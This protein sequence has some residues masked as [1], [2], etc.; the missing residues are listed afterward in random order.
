MAP[1]LVA[2]MVVAFALAIAGTGHAARRPVAVIDL[3]GAA[4][5]GALATDLY[6]ALVDHAELKPLDN[7]AFN[8][9]LQGPF[10]D[11]DAP[12]LER[13]QRYRQ[14]A[15][16][17]LAQLDDNNAQRAATSGMNE[18]A[19]VKPTAQMLGLY[20][21]LAFAYGQAQIGLRKP[22]DAALAFQL[23]SR[24]DPTRRPDPTRYQPNIV[25]AYYAAANKQTIA[26]KLAVTGEGRVW[27]DGIEL[28][29]A[30]NTFDTSEGLHVVQLTGMGRETRGEQ[31]LVPV[32]SSVEIASAPASAVLEIKRARLALANARDPAERASAIKRLAKLLGV[33]DAVLI[34]WIDG[35]LT[36]QT[37]RDREPG[38]SARMVYD[39]Q[40]P[41][42]L[43]VPLA[44]PRPKIDIGREPFTPPPIVVEKRWY[45]KNWVRASIAGGI[46]AGIVSAV[47]YARRDKMLPPWDTDPQWKEMP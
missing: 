9:A 13:A 19:F 7:P 2:R 20:A 43:L 17:F 36:V 23:A 39:G 28:G 32:R 10:E 6:N 24:L 5:G 14:E 37:W 45:Q 44:P 27:I 42:D 47:L 12:R 40:R 38:F 35:K 46:I 21:D 18:L 8:P 31:V 29:R 26:A 25:Q 30:G 4:P 3:T 11:E 41:G 15:E 33:G 1:G 34:A 22:N 16:D